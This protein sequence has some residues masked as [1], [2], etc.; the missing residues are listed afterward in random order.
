M[1]KPMALSRLVA[2]GACLLVPEAGPR[3]AED[4]LTRVRALYEAARYEEAL[5]ALAPAAGDEP[6]TVPAGQALAQY[7]ALCLVALGRNA[8]AEKA[9]TDLLHQDPLFRLAGADVSPKLHVL[10]DAV[11]KRALPAII[12]QRYEAGR[13]SFAGDNRAEAAS[14]FKLVLALSADPA[15][16]DPA[17]PSTADL[18][19][20]AAGFLDLIGRAPAG[21]APAHA[22]EAI[23]SADDADVTPPAAVRQTV[24]PW[25]PG[26]GPAPIGERKVLLDVVISETGAVE[27]AVLMTKLNSMYDGALEAASRTW[28]YDPA[29]RNGVAVRYRKVVEVVF[30]LR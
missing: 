30:R 11:R 17:D 7:R 2:L 18:R 20:L 21:P 6:L 3:A 4:A 10:F 13:K 19:M 8:D 23:Y 25:R 27:K 15:A 28:R 16:A 5:A 22:P 12:R 14:H 29:R 24:P 9:V 26:Y 1:K